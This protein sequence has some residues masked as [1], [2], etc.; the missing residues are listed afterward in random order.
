MFIGKLEKNTKL[1]F[2][3]GPPNPGGGRGPDKK[4]RKRRSDAG[5]S[6]GGSGSKD[7]EKKDQRSQ[8]ADKAKN[9]GRAVGALVV[10]DQIASRSN[11]VAGRAGTAIRRRAAV[12]ARRSGMKKTSRVLSRGPRP[13][14]RAARLATIGK[15]A[16]GL[17]IGDAAIQGVS[18]AVGSTIENRHKIRDRA[19]D[20][21]DRR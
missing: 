18:K 19:K 20:L 9:T 7:D 2:Q 11:D 3:V 13:N 10:G 8:L 15:Y 21:R 4:P 1:E 17:A 12:A 16:A 6:R 5:I 14:T